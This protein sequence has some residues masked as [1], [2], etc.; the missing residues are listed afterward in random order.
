MSY[1]AVVNIC[2]CGDWEKCLHS[3][4]KTRREIPATHICYH[5]LFGCVIILCPEDTE[6]EFLTRP[7]EYCSIF[8]LEHEGVK[9]TC[10]T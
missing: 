3:S 6:E 8:V 7:S 1:G 2:R 9:M 5:P 4:I 10:H